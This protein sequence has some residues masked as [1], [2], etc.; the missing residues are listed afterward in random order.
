LVEEALRERLDKELSLPENREIY[1][2]RQ[3]KAELV[4]GHIKRNLGV[5]SFLLRGLAG[6]RAETSLLSSCFNLRRMMTLLGIAGLIQEL[7][8]VRSHIFVNIWL[9]TL[10]VKQM[11]TF[12]WSVLINN[13]LYKA[14]VINCDT[15]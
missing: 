11:L 5:S 15:V 1:N 14:N 6:V 12:F 10:S 7:R 13:G 9:I 8:R 4:Y 3:Q 2:R